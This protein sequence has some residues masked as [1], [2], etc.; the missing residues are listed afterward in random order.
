MIRG[1]PRYT[2]SDTLI[3]STTLFRSVGGRIAD[4]AD[5]RAAVMRA[6]EAYH[7]ILVDAVARYTDAADEPVA[8]IDG[9]RSRKDL[10][11]VLQPV[12]PRRDIGQR[13]AALRRVGRS[14]EH[15]SELQSLMRI[16]Y[17]VFCLKKKKPRTDKTQQTM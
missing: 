3:P 9:D 13:R 7:V 6:E 17:A 15:K 4:A 14:E 8:A 11:A 16:S 10:N 2:R 1:P 5:A 12:L